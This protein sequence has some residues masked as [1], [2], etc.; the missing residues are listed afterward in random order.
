MASF[1]YAALV[2]FV[3]L[4]VYTV[5][6]IPW[7]RLAFDQR[8]QITGAALDYMRSLS[9]GAAKG[10]AG[11]GGSLL[12]VLG[13]IVLM[14]FII[15]FALFF[16][17][18]PATIE[19]I[20]M[21]YGATLQLQLMV[22]F[23]IVG[24]PLL[25]KVWPKG[26]A[27]AYAAFRESIRQPLFW[28]LFSLGLTALLISPLVPYFTF[29]EDLVMVK[30]LG[31]DTMMLAAALFGTIAA[32]QSIAEEIEGRTAITLM[33]KPVSRRQFLL[34]KFLGIL[35]AALLMFG[36]LSW[37]FQGVLLFKGWLDRA[38]PTPTPV[39][40]TSALSSMNLARQPADLVRGVGLWA[41]HT[42]SVLPGLVMTFSEVMVLIAVA[43]ALATR[44]T[45][46]VNLATVLAIYFLANVA[47]V[48]VTIG[49]QAKE[50]AAK[51]NVTD[52]VAELLS[53]TAGLFD[54]L[55]PALD[56]FR[57]GPALVADAVVPAGYVLSVA[58]Y[59]LL[60][61][62]IL[63]LVGLILFEDRDLA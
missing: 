35:L 19:A 1:F 32:S 37:A 25:M 22:A 29:G 52:P 39:W 57:I 10:A 48:L 43:V 9:T 36:L 8:G 5:A 17:G 54:L 13:V 59:G 12:I 4:V 15:V 53:F 46:V 63:L 23:F 34:G 31:F 26:G 62:L 41:D 40:L 11:L 50:H 33:S 6:A 30:D 2:A 42:A 28:V 51:L 44:A 55:L 47:P 60:Y 58:F 18:D 49:Q 24:F 14:P 7:V 16:I 3:L 56:Y 21:L 61:T 27:V 38:D 20:G 45:M